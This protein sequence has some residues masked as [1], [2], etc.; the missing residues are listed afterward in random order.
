MNDEKKWKNEI[1]VFVKVH[2]CLIY[3]KMI[4]IENIL[5][6]LDPICHVNIFL[7]IDC[8]DHSLCMISSS[9]HTVEVTYEKPNVIRHYNK[10][11]PLYRYQK[12]DFQRRCYENIFLKRVNRK[13]RKFIFYFIV[14]NLSSLHLTII[15]IEMFYIV[16]K[17]IR[18]C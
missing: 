18:R 7:A 16:I 15:V 10:T 5:K 2:Y 14:E 4:F 12:S 11:N 13:N 8:F 3:Y 6:L 9:L 17:K 1:G